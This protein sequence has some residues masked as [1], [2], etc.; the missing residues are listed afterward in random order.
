VYCSDIKGLINELKKNCYKAE[1][2]RLFIGSS[3]RSIKAVLLHNISAPANSS[4]NC[5]GGK[6]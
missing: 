6:V 1:D 2:W 3:K 5:H 4:L